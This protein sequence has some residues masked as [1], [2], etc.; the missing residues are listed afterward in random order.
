MTSL[1]DTPIVAAAAGSARRRAL[2]AKSPPTRPASA[3]RAA[4]IQRARAE[5]SLT[6]FWPVGVEWRARVGPGLSV[7]LRVVQAWPLADQRV[8]VVAVQVA[9]AGAPRTVVQGA[10]SPALCI[11]ASDD[12]LQIVRQQAANGSP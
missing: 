7:T 8:E 12:M 2:W 1:A 3:A 4:G 10:L 6:Q 9:D 11:V 5:P